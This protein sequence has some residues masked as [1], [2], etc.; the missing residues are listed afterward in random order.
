MRRLRILSGLGLLA[1][2][3]MLT[4]CPDEGLIGAGSGNSAPSPSSSGSA[5]P[6]PTP[7]PA[8]SGL[9]GSIEK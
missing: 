7:K 2:T 8:A 1:L 4:A 6:A 3:L 5:T 9:S